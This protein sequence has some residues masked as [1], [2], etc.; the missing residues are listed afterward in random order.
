MKAYLGKEAKEQVDLAG[1][2]KIG[3]GSL[4][5]WKVQ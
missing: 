1:S 5:V 2:S 3:I 4:D